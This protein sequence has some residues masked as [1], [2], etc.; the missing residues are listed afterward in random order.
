MFGVLILIISFRMFVSLRL[1]LHPFFQIFSSIKIY[2]L[3][4]KVHLNY[5]IWKRWKQRGGKTA[6]LDNAKS[7]E[8]FNWL[9]D[10]VYIKNL[11]LKMC[12]VVKRFFPL[13]VTNSLT[14]TKVPFIP[15]DG[16]N[17][18]WYQCGPTVYDVSHMGHARWDCLVCVFEKR[19]S[20]FLSH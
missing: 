3:C 18:N 16:L 4:Y 19:K 9:L 14:R 8:G 12:C 13:R 5:G 2:F 6:Y 17:V 20:H 1:Q 7:N 15:R 10:Q 11:F